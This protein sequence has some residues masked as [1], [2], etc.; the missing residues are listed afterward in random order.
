[1]T[2]VLLSVLIL[3]GIPIPVGGE[4]DNVVLTRGVRYN[5]T[6]GLSGRLVASKVPNGMGTLV[7]NVFPG[8][9]AYLI[10]ESLIA[11]DDATQGLIGN[12]VGLGREVA[13]GVTTTYSWT[14]GRITQAGEIARRGTVTTRQYTIELGGL[15][16]Q[17]GV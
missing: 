8:D 6:P 15:S 3:N 5:T 12:I 4:D 17:A 13:D 1:M 11:T 16:V 9:A 14:Q 7:I 10:L 2:N